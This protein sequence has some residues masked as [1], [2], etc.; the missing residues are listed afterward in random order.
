MIMLFNKPL[1]IVTAISVLAL[2]AAGI[3]I[4]VLIA[5]NA[6]L[7]ADNKVKTEQIISMEKDIL[8]QQ[9]RFERTLETLELR[10]EKIRVIERNSSSLKKKLQELANSED[11]KCINTTHSPTIFDLLRSD[12]KVS[13]KADPSVPAGTATQ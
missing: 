10:D 3:Y 7:E 12:N 6:L 5:N 4:K 13:D 9:E 11:D 1:L 2:G 8:S